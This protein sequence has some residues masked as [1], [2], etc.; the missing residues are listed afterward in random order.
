VFTIDQ[1]LDMF[2][3][4]SAIY[5]NRHI[6]DRKLSF[7]MSKLV[8]VPYLEPCQLEM[9]RN[10]APGWDIIHGEEELLAA[11]LQD[12]EI[13]AGWNELTEQH[14]LQPE[15]RLR[16]IQAWG[17]GVE[18]MPFDALE[19]RNVIL[20]NVS[21]IHAYP[22][23]ESVLAMMLSFTRKLHLHIRNQTQKKWEWFGGVGEMHGK[24]LGVVGVG[25]I[26]EEIAKL[27]RAFGMRVLGVRKSGQACS[28]VDQMYDNQGLDEVFRESD[29]VVVTLPIT[30]ETLHLIGR[31][32]FRLM[33]STAFYINIGRGG[34]TH[35]EALIEALQSGTIAGAGLDVFE[36]EPLPES[37]PLWEMDNVILTPHNSGASIHY[38]DRAV[39]IFTANLQDYVNGS[40]PSLNRVDLAS[41]Y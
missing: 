23:S 13:V 20:T 14:C 26:G 3:I 22:I 6:R 27:A 36:Q 21:G 7:K 1:G 24:V 38:N 31:S 18:Q 15:S 25:A 32:Q 9:I 11:H 33:K 29:Y 39:Q 10:A 34:T 40:E 30:K 16:W 8:C 19:R 2:K 12:A 4:L 37:S 28:Y 17:A 35:T 5:P 41:R